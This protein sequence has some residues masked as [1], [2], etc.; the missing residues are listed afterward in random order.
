VVEVTRGL[1]DLVCS[2][3]SYFLRC[4]SKDT[5]L[6][7]TGLAS[8]YHYW[9]VKTTDTGYLTS[10]FSAVDSFYVGPDVPIVDYSP[11]N[12]VFGSQGGS[13]QVRVKNI[14]RGQ[15]TWS[16]AKVCNWFTVSTLSGG[17]NT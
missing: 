4:S 14:G 10:A 2:P 1:G 13:L 5:A 3:K 12:T 16:A 17:N 11:K 7:V 8:G 6:T 15:L 9:R